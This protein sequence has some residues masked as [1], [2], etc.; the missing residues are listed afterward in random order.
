M[1]KE[2]Q[3]NMRFEAQKNA[4]YKQ[5]GAKDRIK[6]HAFNLSQSKGR[7]NETPESNW[8]EAERLELEN[9]QNQLDAKRA[10]QARNI[11]IGLGA[12]ALAGMFTLGAPYCESNEIPKI[13]TPTP[14]AAVGEPRPTE[15]PR[16]TVKP[17]SNLGSELRVMG[18]PG[19]VD[20]ANIDIAKGIFKNTIGFGSEA[21]IAEPGGLNKIN[22]ILKTKGPEFWNLPESGF[23]LLSLGQGRIKIGDVTFNLPY[24]ENNNYLFIAR[25]LYGDIKQN[26]DKNTTMEVSEYAPGHAMVFMIPSEKNT[27]VAF[28]SQGQFKQMVKTS[29]TEGTNCGDGGCSTVTAVMFD[30]N[31]KAYT[32]MEQNQGRIGNPQRGW[33]LV[34][35][36]FAK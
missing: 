10:K 15:T 4:F 18:V 1:N 19:S 25:G 7:I 23:S 12:V 32:I 8:S 29:H 27:N 13:S 26:T 21:F 17:E 35:S 20:R 33:K 30:A 34:A 36:N 16:I 11:F 24:K 28:F 31:T 9:F 3:S 22:E 5:K 6:T 2:T 14:N